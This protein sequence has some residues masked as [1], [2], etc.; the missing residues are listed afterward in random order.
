VIK[1]DSASPAWA[2]A[3]Y[4]R[5]VGWVKGNVQERERMTC[6]PHFSFARLVSPSHCR[7]K[8]GQSKWEGARRSA[9]LT[10]SRIEREADGGPSGF[11][12]AI[13]AKSLAVPGMPPLDTWSPPAAIP[14]KRQNTE[15]GSPA[16][17]QKVFHILCWFT[18][19]LSI[20][21]FEYRKCKTKVSK[22]GQA[23]TNMLCD[24]RV[25]NGAAM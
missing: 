17:R 3:V 11:L 21:T 9:E 5:F 8:A 13:G 24:W 18:D 22:S 10:E 2:D 25:R 20:L 7:G 1:F 19:K 4:E 23:V 15:E 14:H 16:K 12:K 6:G